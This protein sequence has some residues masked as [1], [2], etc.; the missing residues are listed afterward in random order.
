MD[1]PSEEFKESL[2]I[3]MLDAV[4]LLHQKHI[5]HGNITTNHFLFSSSK[6]YPALLKLRNL[7]VTSAVY[8]RNTENSASVNEIQIPIHRMDE[9]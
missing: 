2:A 5:A 3:Q 4:N 9:I 8:L 6:N 1:P 7:K